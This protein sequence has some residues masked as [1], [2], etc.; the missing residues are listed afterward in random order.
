MVRSFFKVIF[1][2]G[3]TMGVCAQAQAEKKQKST[4]VEDIGN[5]KNKAP[6]ED[7]DS[8]ITNNRMRAESG[9]KSKISLTSE[10]DYFGSTFNRPFTAVRPNIAASTATPTFAIMKGLISGKYAFNQQD[11]LSGGVGVRWVTP[12]QGLNK[13]VGWEGD[14]VDAENPFLMYQH[15]YKWSGIQSVL[16]VQ[17]T[18]YTNSEKLK[19]RYVTALAIAQNNIY[20]VG[21]TGL[22]LGLY[23]LVQGNYYSG[24]TLSNDSTKDV[25]SD[26]SD[27]QINIDPFIEYQLTSKINLRTVTNL[28]NYEHLR[29]MKAHTYLWDKVTQSVGVGFSITRDVFLY[30]NVQFLPDKMGMNDT[31]VGLSAFFNL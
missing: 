20:E 26:Q 8:L 16:Q 29:S 12:L 14:K 2:I 15:I 1:A 3:L 18:F 4:D 11:S 27:Y 9:A 13:P 17:P 25:R 22:S 7:V 23:L 19:E 30:P 10:F 5:V 28:W 31:N 6:G 21:D 24:K